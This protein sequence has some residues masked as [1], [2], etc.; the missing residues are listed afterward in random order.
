MDRNEN[1]FLGFLEITFP[2]PSE[3][4]YPF[5]INDVP[6]R[7]NLPQITYKGHQTVHLWP[8]DR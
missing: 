1:I 6:V 4:L 2:I 7:Y 8:F 5:V 3:L